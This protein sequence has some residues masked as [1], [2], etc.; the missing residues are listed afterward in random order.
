[1]NKYAFPW[2]IYIGELTPKEDIAETKDIPVLLPSEK[3]GFC[4]DYDEESETISNQFIEN[5]V[6]LLMQA[7]PPKSLHI[8]T[9]DFDTAPRFRYLSQLKAHK[10]YHLYANTEQAK[11]GFDE[12]E[13][14][15]RHRLHDLLPPEIANLS[16]YNQTVQYPENYHLLLIN[17]D[18]YPDDFIGVKR[19]KSFFES[20]SKAGFYT[21]FYNGIEDDEEL[22]G[23]REKSLSYIK[24][25]FATLSIEDKT[26]SLNTDVFE[27]SQ[28]CEFYDYQLADT[29]QTQIIANIIENLTACEKEN[30]KTDFLQIPIA[31]TQDGRNDVYFSLG[32]NSDNYNAI[33]IGRVGSG[34]SALL[35]NLIVGI[36][37]RYTAQEIQLVL[38]DFN[39][40]VEFNVFAEHPNCTQLFAD[41]EAASM[42]VEVVEG[43][44]N[45]M[46]N[47]MELIEKASV[48]NI[49]QY[50]KKYPDFPM[51]YKIL[52]IDEAHRLFSGN[53][54]QQQYFSGC[55]NKLLREGRKA[56]MHVILATQAISDS[57][58]P[59]YVL[60]QTGLRLSFKLNEPKNARNIFK[61]GNEVALDLD[62]SKHEVL[63]NTDSGN[64]PANIVA[65]ANPP[66]SF[67]D[68]VGAIKQKLQQI[69][70][71]RLPHL[72]VTPQIL[73]GTILEN[74]ETEKQAQP[75]SDS[76]IFIQ[77]NNK[78]MPDWLNGEVE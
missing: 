45:E 17:L 8:H 41:Y 69:K 63:I 57:D 28:L 65:L 68:E 78:T 71:S 3:G 7:L 11:K 54:R 14:I 76:N 35:N 48:K 52:I 19:I 64:M 38:M 4:V 73:K 37:E 13:E 55:L 33:I 26:A 22:K 12:L 75:K 30:T 1:M 20:A 47:R 9:F 34:K 72:I 46:H 40:G 23:N 74:K 31:K 51:A 10:L 25:K 21:I 61:Y 50:N 2:G 32:S 44:L 70:A 29:N 66:L 60:D 62:A 43:F 36:A 39:R 16:E 58:I 59:S 15:A 49:G 56:G 6:L 24:Q 42:A 67:D 5:I 18:Y 77:D 27:C 53:Y